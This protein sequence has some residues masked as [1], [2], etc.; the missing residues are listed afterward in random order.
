MASQ[1]KPLDRIVQIPETYVVLPLRNAVFFP[2]QVLPLSVGRESSLRVLEE[3]Q[4]DNLP[5]LLL[6]QRDGTVTSPAAA[7]LHTLGTLGKILKVFTLPDGTKSILVQGLARARVLSFLQ[8][9]PYIKVVAHQIEDEAAAGI[10]IEALASAIKSVFHKVVELSPELNEEQLSVVLNL[11]EPGA[12]ADIAISMLSGGLEEKQA[13]LETLGVKERLQRAHRFLITTLQGLE[14]GNKIQ[15]DVQEEITK[16]QREFYLREQLKAINKELGDDADSAETKEL[17]QRAEQAKLPEEVRKTVEKELQR[18]ARMHSSSAESTVA[19]TYIEWLLDL[20]WLV[21]TP[22]N[23]D[24]PKARQVLESDHYGLEKVKNR[25]LEYL[26]VRKLKNDMRG[27]ILCFV[28]PP[29][30]GK[31][32]LGKSIANALGRKFIRISLGGVHDEAEIRGHRRTYIGALPGRIIQGLKKAGSNNPV[33]MLDEVDKLGMDFHGD[34]SSALLEVLDPEQNNSFNDHYIDQPFDLSQVL[35]IATAN[36]LDPILP[37]LRDRMEIVE[38]PSYVEEEK[39]HI[40][41]RFLIPKQVKEH[42]LQEESVL[43]EDDAIRQIIHGYTREAGVRS[44]ER[45]IAEVSRGVARGVAEGKTGQ[46]VVRPGDLTGFMGKQRFYAE[47]AE[48]IDRP[49]IATG[50]AWTPV[51][52]DILFVEATKM[53]GRGNLVL[54]GQLGDVMKESALA[55]LSYIASNAGSLN[56]E[57]RFR[58]QHDIHIHVPAGATPKDG[59]SAGVTIFSALVSLLTGRLVRKDLAM[60]GEITLRGAVLPVGGIREKVLAAHRAGIKVIILP[61]RNK[62]DIDE[63]PAGIAASLEFH[64][65]KEMAE[66]LRWALTP[67]VGLTKADDAREVA[68]VVVN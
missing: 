18:L 47:V 46:Q 49:G 64:F 16:T 58:L 12:L 37:P 4:R 42:G 36:M 32:S 33:F 62:N 29:G 45:R 23:I 35:F 13:I 14:L 51:G 1:K 28:G 21:S 9:E 60:T 22:D 10:E 11:G 63:L 30:V 31:T 38:I 27:P 68:R 20:P 2:R 26:A 57:D 52:G 7:D 40:A 61:E 44:L 19:R 56:V 6:T 3:A 39:L 54:T 17:R 25:I 34:P 59:P 66:V 43:F 55:A 15:S 50:L 8:V 48:R 41:K 65:V 24:I 53:K 67:Q 5:I